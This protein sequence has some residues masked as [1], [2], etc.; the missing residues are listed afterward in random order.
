VEDAVDGPRRQ[1]HRL[2]FA[3]HFVERTLLESCGELAVV[4]E[5]DLAIALLDTGTQSSLFSAVTRRGG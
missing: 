2:V 5:I 1:S 4:E 3:E